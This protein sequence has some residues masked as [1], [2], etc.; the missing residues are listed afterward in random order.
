MRLV[1]R[2]MADM[3]AKRALARFGVPVDISPAQALLAMVH[4]AAGN[5]AYLSARID[6]MIEQGQAAEHEYKADILAQVAAVADGEDSSDQGIKI[7]RG[8]EALFGPI[9]S[10][11]SKGDLYATQETQRAIVSMY[12][13]WTDRLVKYSKAAID[14]GVAKAQVEL[15]RQ[16]GQMLIQIIKTVMTKLGFDVAQTREAQL[17]LAV[18]MRRLAAKDVTPTLRELA[19]AEKPEKKSRTMDT[20][21]G[22]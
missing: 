20:G 2:Q 5:V 1:A 13:E 10:A 14:A 4:E 17:L 8:A 7:K 21:R 12:G 22:F 19:D 3:D 6:E 11:T 15:A 16:Q 18:E 9:V